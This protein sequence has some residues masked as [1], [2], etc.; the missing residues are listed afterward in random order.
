MRWVLV[1]ALLGAPAATP[2]AAATTEKLSFALRQQTL[3]LTVYRPAAPPRGTIIMGSG[4][5]GW[6]GLAAGM[7]GFL[8]S[9]GYLVIGLNVRQYL[10]SFTAGSRHLTT[11]EPPADYRALSVFLS[12]AGLLPRPVL[13]SGVSEG[14][15]LAMLAAA[16]PKNHAWIDGVVAMGVPAT[17]ELAWRW[18]DVAAL[19]T[20]RDLAEPWFAPH[21][22]AAAVSPVPLAMIQSSTDEY[23]T[24]LDR[25]RLLAAARPP[26]KM[27]MID[28]A[29]HRF[30][31]RIDELHQRFIDAMAWALGARE[32]S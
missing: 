24:H 31:D 14:A 32:A 28:A 13:L 2:A 18:S 30:T 10:A 25:T 9:Q 16:D 19:I 6:L 8:S 23:A 5:A 12:G 4:D 15:A 29:N 26:R 21:E 17:A 7:A 1:L 3:T 20:R 11:E 27:V 22:F